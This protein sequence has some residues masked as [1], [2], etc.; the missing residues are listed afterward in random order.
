MAMMQGGSLLFTTDKAQQAAKPEYANMI[1]RI[2][3]K[4]AES[5]TTMQSASDARVPIYT[6]MIIALIPDEAK[7][8]QLLKERMDERAAIFEKFRLEDREIRGEMLYHVDMTYF[9]KYIS[10]FDRWIGIVKKQVILEIGEDGE[11]VINSDG[12]V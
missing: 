7:R 5:M 9:G 1:F 12:E 2:I 3:E 11:E 4:F 6:D 10:E 8:V